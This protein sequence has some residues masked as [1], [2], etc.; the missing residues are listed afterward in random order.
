[1]NRQVMAMKARV[2]RARASSRHPLDIIEGALG[3]HGLPNPTGMSVPDG[4]AG[5]GR[6]GATFLISVP[7]AM[8]ISA[9]ADPK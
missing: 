3:G 7:Q 5:G 9:P 2:T 1:M 6:S 8:K 4:V